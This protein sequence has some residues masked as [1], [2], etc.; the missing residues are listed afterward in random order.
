MHTN[1]RPDTGRILDGKAIATELQSDIAAQIRTHTDQGRRAPGLAVVQVGQDPASAIY[2]QRKSNACD[3]VGIASTV[4]TLPEDTDQDSLCALIHTLNADPSIDGILVQLPLPA[5]INT[6]RVLDTVA[7]HKDV[8]G[9]HPHNMGLLAQ[10]RPLLRPCTP[11]GIMKMLE[12]ARINVHGKH[13]VMVGTSD[14]VGRPMAL[15][16]L[17]ANATV[18][19]CHKYTQDLAQHIQQ[20]DILIVAIGKTGVIDS[21]WIQ[22]GT[23]VIDVGINRMTNRRIVGDIDFETARPRA[24][25]ITPVPG[26]VGPM[27]VTMLLHN[28]L[29]AYSKM[30]MPY[31]DSPA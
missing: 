17:L 23:I 24:A 6:H 28:T 15:E 2:V 13:A 22:P 7:P 31:H 5:H 25:W 21:D 16:L 11:Y 19:L 29:T 10:R 3:A 14:I 1:T 4:H 26:G 18:T 30:P 12:H 27:T 9:F 8:D 20:A